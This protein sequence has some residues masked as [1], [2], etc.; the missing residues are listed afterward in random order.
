[1]F[2]RKVKFSPL[3]IKNWTLSGE[4]SSFSGRFKFSGYFIFVLPLYY[5]L[6]QMFDF[7]FLVKYGG[8][9]EGKGRKKEKDF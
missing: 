2:H 7:E 3:R 1:M 4:K 5:Q 9:Q 8:N 6:P